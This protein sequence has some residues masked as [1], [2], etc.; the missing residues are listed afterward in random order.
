M[1]HDEYLLHIFW[2]WIVWWAKQHGHNN[3]EIINHIPFLGF[4]LRLLCLSVLSPFAVTFSWWVIAYLIDP[5]RYAGWN[6]N[7]PG[8]ASQVR[9]IEGRDQTA[10]PILILP[11]DFSL[12]FLLINCAFLVRI[13]PILRWSD[14]LSLTPNSLLCFTFFLTRTLQ[15]WWEYNTKKVKRNKCTKSS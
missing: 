6:F 2:F 7:T 3:K 13:L 12:L 15:A 8:R 4:N 9:Q 1:W 10:A 5:D 14:A 11:F